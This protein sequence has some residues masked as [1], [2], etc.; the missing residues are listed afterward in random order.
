MKRKLT[1]VL[2]FVG[3]MAMTLSMN[4]FVFAA[5]DDIVL[6]GAGDERA[7]LQKTLDPGEEGEYKYLGWAYAGESVD[8]AYKYLKLTYSGSDECF[9][10]IR[11]ELVEPDGSP[12]GPGVLQKIVWFGENPEGTFKT[13]EGKNCPDAT[14]KDQTVWI[15]LEKSGYDLSRGIRAFHIHSTPGLGKVEFKEAVLSKEAPGAEAAPADDAKTVETEAPEETT[16]DIEKIYPDD[17]KNEDAKEETT[18]S[19]NSNLVLPIAI[20][21]GAVVVAI[22]VIVATKKK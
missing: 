5:E 20:V 17:E 18:S 12:D 8:P 6:D 16:V 10:Q 19:D 11:L 21:G 1:R 15:D 3:A 4:A 13:V 22:A 9:K 14:D 2:A 7:A